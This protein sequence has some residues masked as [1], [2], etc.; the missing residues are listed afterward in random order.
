MGSVWN[1]I[2]A[3]FS[4]KKKKD[5]FRWRFKGDTNT[6]KPHRNT[7]KHRTEQHKKTANRIEI[8][9]KFLNTVN[10]LVL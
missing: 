9:R 5:P 7:Y 1:I 10:R 2:P 3:G 8:T 4:Q 6:P